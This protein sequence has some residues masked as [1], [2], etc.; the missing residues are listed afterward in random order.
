MAKSLTL[1]IIKRLHDAFV[2]KNWITTDD[3]LDSGFDT[4]FDKYCE[5]LALLSPEEQQ[6]ILDLT[7]D[8]QYFPFNRYNSL[9]FKAISC[10]TKEYI[11]YF[12]DIYIVP[13]KNPED[14]KKL[15]SDSSVMYPCKHEILKK[16]SVDRIEALDRLEM[17]G[18]T[19]ASRTNS[20]I[21]FVDDFIGTGETAIAAF[22]EYLSKYAVDDDEVIA[23]S[24]VAQEMGLAA[25]KEFGIA[26][27]NAV[28]INKG[29]S[30]S[31]VISDK[32]TAF[33]LMDK[34]E[35]RL[36]IPPLYKRGYK[37]SE[38][39]V[40]LIRTPDNTFPVFWNNSSVGSEVW[41]AP[42]YR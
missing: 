42:F 10:I 4:L 32:L 34:I 12:D 25:I 39:L 23:V 27:Y 2:V 35:R 5:M 20:L 22:N 30:D 37:A 15:K 19:A 24:L 36:K 41:P 28:T 14:E 38:A 21:I 11:T 6:L 40:S 7:L 29:I 31:E 17:L 16:F 8:F 18:G 1:D 26:A 13:M 9:L 3:N 33:A